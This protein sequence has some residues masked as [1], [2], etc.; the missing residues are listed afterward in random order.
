MHPYLHKKDWL[1]CSHTVGVRVSSPN[2]SPTIIQRLIHPS[3]NLSNLFIYRIYI[4]IP[5]HQGNYSETLRAQAKR[6]V[7]RRPCLVEAQW[8]YL[9]VEC[10]F[11]SLAGV[12]STAEEFLLKRYFKNVR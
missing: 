3:I 11:V 6:K 8:L 12:G 1:E 9:A 5:P 2:P 10:V 4:Y 7:I